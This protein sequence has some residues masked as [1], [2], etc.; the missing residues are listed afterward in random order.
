[1]TNTLP[2]YSV[3]DGDPYDGALLTFAPTGQAARVLAHRDSSWLC[4]AEFIEV[5]ARRLSDGPE[6]AH[7]RAAA[8][9]AGP[10]VVDS[11]PSCKR[12]GMWGARTAEG[13]CSTCAEGE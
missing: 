4:D 1:M 2:M 11:P 7:L 3:F 9:S 10:H 8:E 5:R 12:C 13:E 6:T